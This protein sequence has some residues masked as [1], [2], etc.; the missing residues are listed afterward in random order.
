MSPPGQAHT[1]LERMAGSYT[2]SREI[3]GHRKSTLAWN[4]AALWPHSPSTGL[5]RWG[6]ALDVE[7][8]VLKYSPEPSR[9]GLSM[10]GGV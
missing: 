7:Q 2:S 5:M 9:I 1:R 4:T 3:V 10:G 8:R 6:P